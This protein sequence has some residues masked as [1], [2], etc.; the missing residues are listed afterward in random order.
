MNFEKDT[1]KIFF[2]L[3]SL[4]FSMI[5]DFF[6]TISA[7]FMKTLKSKCALALPPNRFASR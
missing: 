7:I 3:K 2:F 6:N 1:Y 4:N 5:H